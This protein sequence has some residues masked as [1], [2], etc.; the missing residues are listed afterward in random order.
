MTER[1]SG[2]LGVAVLTVSDTRDESTDTSGSYLV[3]AVQNAGHQLMDRR[4]VSDDKYVIRAVLSTWIA[5]PEIAVILVSGGT[6]YGDR[7][8]TPDA[9]AV[10]FDRPIEGFGE[11]FRQLS[12]HEIGSSTIQ[13]RAIAGI[14][15]RTA[16]FCIPGSTGACRTA[17]EQI[18]REQLDASHRPCNFVSALTRAEL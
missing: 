10:L 18:I 17:W 9:A 1:R 3:T 5:A 11:L 13:S 7:D 14:A 6:G 16:I 15:N 12:Y 2:S 8:V 4:L